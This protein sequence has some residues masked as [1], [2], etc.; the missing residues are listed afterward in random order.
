MV[1]ACRLLLAAHITFEGRKPPNGW[2][3]CRRPESG[4]HRSSRLVA[5]ATIGLLGTRGIRLN[6][7]LRG[8]LIRSR[9]H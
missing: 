1:P 7:G 3:V 2:P 6:V 4:E 9:H 8:R 5:V